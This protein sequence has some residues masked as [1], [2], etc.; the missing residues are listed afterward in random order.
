[1]PETTEIKTEE[2]KEKKLIINRHTLWTIPNILTYIRFLLVPVY[3]TFIILSAKLDNDP[4]LFI[5][6]GIMV[7]AA[8]TDVIDGKIARK[9]KGQGTYLGQCIDPIA[10]KAMHIG[11]IVALSV[12]GYLHWIFI[13]LLVFRELCM[14][15]I[16]SFIVNNYEIKANMMGK[17]ASATISVGIILCFFHKWISTIWG[18][19]GIDWIIV[20]IGIAL[21]WFAAFNYGADVARHYK[22]LKKAE[23]D[24]KLVEK[25]NDATSSDIEK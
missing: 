2:K 25:I 16:G 6:L 5:G 18:E 9:Y 12:G 11:A 7:F 13:V 14:I 10:D 24:A 8:C 15:V 1:M 21:N 23:A 17:V 3:M 19:Y 20:T 22:S 4:Y